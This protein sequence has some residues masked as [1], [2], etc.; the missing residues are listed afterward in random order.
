M[1]AIIRVSQL[2]HTPD[3][4]NN[5]FSAETMGFFDDSSITGVGEELVALDRFWMQTRTNGAAKNFNEAVLP[6]PRLDREGNIAAIFRD[7]SFY[8]LSGV[9]LGGSARIGLVDP[10]SGAGGGSINIAGTELIWNF[11][12]SG[13]REYHLQ[14]TRVIYPQPST[15]PL[16]GAI[17]LF[18]PA[19][20][21]LGWLR[22]RPAS[23]AT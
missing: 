5:G 1:I 18:A 8:I 21:G 9:A 19:L 20:F 4:Q 13:Q 22:R 7:G 16:P 15:V 6:E 17:W 10:G 14:Q 23:L 11:P 12:I 2:W 3:F